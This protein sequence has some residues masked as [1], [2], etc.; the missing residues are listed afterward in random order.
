MVVGILAYLDTVAGIW[1][2]HFHCGDSLGAI[3]YFKRHS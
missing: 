3:D 1:V 2:Y